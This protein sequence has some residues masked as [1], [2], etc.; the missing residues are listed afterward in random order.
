[1]V[2]IFG[3]WLFSFIIIF[4]RVKNI[5]GILY[6]VHCVTIQHFICVNKLLLV[7]IYIVNSV[8]PLQ[9]VVVGYKT[10]FS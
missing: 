2:C 10:V 8:L 7:D 6:S 5:W 1:M 4:E 3:V 9:I